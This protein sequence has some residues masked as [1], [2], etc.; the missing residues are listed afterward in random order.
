MQSPRIFLSRS[1]SAHRAFTLIEL[2]VVIAIIA[3]LA[4]ILFP[5]FAQAKAAAKQ[6]MC[7]SNMKQLGTS[8]TMYSNDFDDV[9][10]PRDVGDFCPF[11]GCGAMPGRMMGPV[12]PY[13]KSFGILTCPI[14]PDR[15]IFVDPMHT[16]TF[17]TGALTPEQSAQWYGWKGDW[18]WAMSYG[19]NDFNQTGDQYWYMTPTYPYQ[20]V[21]R[22][23]ITS[24]ARPAEVLMLA[25]SLGPRG[26]F[27]NVGW[28]LQWLPDSKAWDYAPVTDVHN[29]GAPA[30]FVDSHSKYIKQK[31]AHSND[32]EPRADNPKSIWSVN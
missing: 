8:F 31:W 20:G 12:Y 1:Q 5:V 22:R 7:L 14:E 16:D 24:I 29:G 32:M 27:W 10:P 28:N 15:A 23:A 11:G 26:A 13:Y 25:H 6:T 3:I 30:V 19:Y 17:V 18:G 9:L 21:N 4:A 2:L